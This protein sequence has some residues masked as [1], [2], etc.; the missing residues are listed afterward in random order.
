MEPTLTVA[1][2]AL[3]VTDSSGKQ[4]GR[5][6]GDHNILGLEGLRQTVCAGRASQPHFEQG[7]EGGSAPEAGVAGPSPT[8]ENLEPTL[9]RDRYLRSW[10]GQSVKIE[11]D[12]S[13]PKPMSLEANFV[14]FD[15]IVGEI[16]YD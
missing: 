2:A 4:G 14:P 3:M 1:K 10:N 15:Q 5:G 16:N 8:E 11:P 12:I 9:S 13:F 7:Y 6:E